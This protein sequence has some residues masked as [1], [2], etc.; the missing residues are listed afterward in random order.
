MKNI[1][2]KISLLATILMGA[3][4]AP[5]PAYA[6]IN[7]N[8][9]ANPKEEIQCGSCQAAGTL[10]NCNPGASAGTLGNTIKQV[11]TVISV[12][13]G[14]AA[15]I[16]I[17]IGGFRY[18]TSAGNSEQAKGARNTIVYAIIGLIIIAMAQL[19]VHFTLNS[20]DTTCT[21]GKTPAG[22]AC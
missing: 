3:A 22:Q 5:L 15:V 7:C 17:I 11:I 4:M 10:D 12:V 6:A 19:I 9:P 21:K 14:A 20:I 18:V 13:G 2:L 8:S 16:M 1:F